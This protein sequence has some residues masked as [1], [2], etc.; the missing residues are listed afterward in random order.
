MAVPLAALL[1]L[2][3]S[4]VSAGSQ[5]LTNISQ[6]KSNLDIYNR[7]RE[8]ALADWNKQNL[9]NSPK[10][11]MARYKDAGLNPHLIYGQTQ[12]AQ[13]V[14]S[15]DYKAPNY[16]APQLDLSPNVNPM[17]IQ[18]QIDNIKAN[19][20]KANSETD[21]KNLNTKVLED[22]KDYVIGKSQWDAFK[23]KADLEKTQY[24]TFVMQQKLKPEINQILANTDLTTDKKALVAKQVQSLIQSMELMKQKTITEKQQ[25]E[26]VQ[27]VDS[28]SKVGGLGVKLLSLLF[29]R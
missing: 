24:Q 8:D 27:Q 2:I 11:Q 25:N 14:R 18:A 3:G 9:Y 19:T 16:V 4:A 20:L 7:Q 1:P 15:S 13:P 12:T 5:V 29:N 21:W 22:K 10:E 28:V 23:S 26:F 6:K 17:L